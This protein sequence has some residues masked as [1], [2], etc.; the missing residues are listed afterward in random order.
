MVMMSGYK[1]NI[2]KST[3]TIQKQKRPRIT[4]H[5]WM[6]VKEKV[7]EENKNKEKN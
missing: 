2:A 4:E 6:R 7:L 3:Y 5:E 1:K